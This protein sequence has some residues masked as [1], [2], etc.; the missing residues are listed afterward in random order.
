MF[1]K[2]EFIS[3]GRDSWWDYSDTKLW[4]NNKNQLHEAES[5]FR[6]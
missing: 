2:M 6:I 1:Q 3:K 5:F 4:A